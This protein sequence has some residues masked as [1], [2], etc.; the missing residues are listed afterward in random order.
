MA[1]E[2]DVNASSTTNIRLDGGKKN[3]KGKEH[4]KSN[5]EMFL[6]P[7][8]S[9][10]LTFHPPLTTEARDD[11]L[12]EKAIDVTAREEWVARVEMMR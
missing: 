5:E 4:Q 8:P 3:R 9:E 11:E 12:G 1:N 2:G 10:A 6:D 7:L